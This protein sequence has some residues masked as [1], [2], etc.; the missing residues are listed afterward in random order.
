MKKRWILGVLF[1]LMLMLTACSEKIIAGVGNGDPGGEDK[2]YYAAG[3][4]VSGGNQL[5]E[6]NLKDISIACLSKTNIDRTSYLVC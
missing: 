4:A 5:T 1:L 6:A 3:Q 2:G